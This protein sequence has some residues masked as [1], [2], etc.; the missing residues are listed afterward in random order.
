MAMKACK[1]PG[2]TA[3]LAWVSWLFLATRPHPKIAATSVSGDNLSDNLWSEMAKWQGKSKFLKEMFVWTKT[4]IFA[5]HHPET[6]FMSARSWSKAADPSKQADTLAGLHA[7]Y[8]MFI[9]DEVGGI[10]DAIV[11]TAEAALA[12]GIECK[13]VMAGNPTQT[14]GPLYRACTKEKHLWWNISITSDPEDPKRTPRVSIEWAKQQI[15]KYGRDNPW[16]LV[17]AFGS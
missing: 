14:S 5:K 13:L 11:A 1:G 10:P 7:D 4:R 3:I 15:E 9:L 16:V 6:W 8:I 2:K 17:N 12:T